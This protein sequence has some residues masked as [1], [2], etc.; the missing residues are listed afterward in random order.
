[1]LQHYVFIKYAQG[2]SDEHIAE[3]CRRM[4]ALVGS[5]SAIRHLEIGRDVL[6]EARSWDLLLVMRFDSVA[7]LREY[8]RHPEHQAV[9]AFNQPHV[10]DV[11]A[12]DF[13]SDS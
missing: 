12:V 6:H 4:Q 13:P 3:F 5:I 2:T 11:G 10:A 8:Q 7:T 1:M 9:M